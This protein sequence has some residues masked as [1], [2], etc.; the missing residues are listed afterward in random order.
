ML[1]LSCLFYILALS[2]FSSNYHISFFWNCTIYNQ[3]VVASPGNILLHQN[4]LNNYLFIN[5]LYLSSFIYFFCTTNSKSTFV[6]YLSYIIFLKIQQ[7]LMINRIQRSLLIKA[8]LLYNY[9]VI[10][11]IW[12]LVVLKCVYI[13]IFNSLVY[14]FFHLFLKVLMSLSC[15]LLPNINFSKHRLQVHFP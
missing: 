9:F 8:C 5:T 7:M 1:L 2:S 4:Q 10:F 15:F 11:K 14:I 13:F 3:T 12:Y 6:S